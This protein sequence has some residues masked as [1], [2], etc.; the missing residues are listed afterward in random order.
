MLST[1]DT[2]HVTARLYFCATR[3]KSY[4]IYLMEEVDYSYNNFGGYDFR[5]IKGSEGVGAIM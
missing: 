1:L 4:I 5:L 2:V 3:V